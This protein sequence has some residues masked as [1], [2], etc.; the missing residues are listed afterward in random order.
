VFNFLN[1]EMHKI[2]INH[3]GDCRVTDHNISDAF[4]TSISYANIFH[5]KES[6][7]YTIYIP[8]L[9]FHNEFCLQNNF[10]CNNLEFRMRIFIVIHTSHTEFL[11]IL[12]NHWTETF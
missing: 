3:P 6:W 5:A 2:K 4:H 9:L 1:G 12:L 11:I 8:A 7:F 10:P